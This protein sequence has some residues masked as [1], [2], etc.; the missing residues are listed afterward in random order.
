LRA[1]Y[2]YDD[3]YLLTVT[4]RVD[5]SSRFGDNH[6]YGLFPSMALAWN[7]SNEEFFNS[8]GFL[9][10]L[11][12]RVS[13]GK[14]GQ[15]GIAPYQTRALLDRTYYNYGSDLGYGYQPSQIANPNLQ[16][17]T[18]ATTNIAL[19]FAIL[20]SRIS[21]SVDIYQQNTNDL[22]LERQL[23]LTSGYESIIENVGS[24]RNTGIEVS[25][26]TVN[27][28]SESRD[29][30]QWTT[31]LNFASNREEIVE[32]YGGGQDDVGNEWFIGEPINVFYTYD[33]VGVW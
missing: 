24:T 21:G 26:S 29:G 25:I 22:L 17:E 3:R 10:N 30:F 28:Q 7:I 4:G 2:N 12:L 6:K 20:N 27:I 1:N 33:Q 15:T 31:D 19:E 16:W 8:E 9:N 23:P 5:G 11:K 18:T 13:W 32:L 14:T